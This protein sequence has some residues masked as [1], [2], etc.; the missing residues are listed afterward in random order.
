MESID[1]T[2]CW[3]LPLEEAAE[4]S[5]RWRAGGR[6][7]SEPRGRLL[8][9][10]SQQGQPR[11]ALASGLQPVGN[12]E[13]APECCRGLLALLPQP[14]P[15]FHLPEAGQLHLQPSPPS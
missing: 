12:S 5:G 6:E 9:G 3:N 15:C 8:E 10:L 7:A 14:G 1:D 11:P 2:L 4:R 13:I